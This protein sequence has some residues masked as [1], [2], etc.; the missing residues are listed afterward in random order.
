MKASQARNMPSDGLGKELEER[1][2]ELFNLRF[3]KASGQLKNTARM[4]SVRREIA[5][6]KTVLRERELLEEEA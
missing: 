6:L 3:Q 4:M 2:Q 1:Y 5:R